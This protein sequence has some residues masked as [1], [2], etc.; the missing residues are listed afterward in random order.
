M[1]CAA[2]KSIIFQQAIGLFEPFE[3][4]GAS[5]IHQPKLT[6]PTGLLLYNCGPGPNF[7]ITDYIA[8]PDLDQITSAQLL[9]MA[10]SKNALSRAR[11]YWSRKKR[12]AQIWRGLSAR[13]APTLRPAFHDTRSPK[14]GS[15]S[16]NPMIHLL[17][18]CWPQEERLSGRQ[19]LCRR[20]AR[21]ERID[22]PPIPL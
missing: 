10:R 15:N 18:P 17:W 19:T 5:V 14:A 11:R 12:I 20:S 1:G 22:L 21:V 6:W 3:Q 4:P 13:F 7:P 2:R 8:D 9:S 16:D